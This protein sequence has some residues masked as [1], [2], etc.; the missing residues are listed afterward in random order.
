MVGTDCRSGRRLPDCQ[1]PL[2]CGE[3]IIA[4]THLGDNPLD[5]PRQPAV[6]LV[7]QLEEVKPVGVQPVLHDDGVVERFPGEVLVSV[8]APILRLELG[9]H[10]LEE[11]AARR[12]LNAS[13]VGSLQPLDH[14]SEE[15]RKGQ[16]IG[17]A[18]L[19]LGRAASVA[20]TSK[21]LARAAVTDEGGER[22]VEGRLPWEIRRVVQQLVDDYLGKPHLVV[23]QQVREQ[24]V[25][26]P[27]QGTERHP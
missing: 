27:T 18:S 19:R 21:E 23:T 1:R 3:R 14:R 13:R 10:G 5:G 7:R 26:E 9:R 6:S 12:Y 22:L 24:R 16:G 17:P 11:G 25:I 8:R 20:A 15:A 4:V 2:Q